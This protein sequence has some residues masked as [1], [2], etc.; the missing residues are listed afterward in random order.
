MRNTRNILRTKKK[1]VEHFWP[2]AG[3]GKCLK[4]LNP[5]D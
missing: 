3:V 4:L 2:L 1:I 5:Q